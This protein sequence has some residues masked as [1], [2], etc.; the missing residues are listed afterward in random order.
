MNKLKNNVKNP[1]FLTAAG[2]LL[3]FAG[4]YLFSGSDVAGAASFADISLA[5]ALELPFAA[6]SVTGAVIHSMLSDSVGKCIVK[7]AA[8]SFIV[9]AKLFSGT[10]GTALSNAIITGISVMLSGTAIS[11]LIGEMPEKLLFYAL[12]ALLSGLAAG[13]GSYLLLSAEKDSVPKFN[14]SSGSCYAV[15]YIL[16]IASFYSIKV[17]AVNIGFIIGAALTL[18]GA[19]FYGSTGG[20]VCGALTA[21]GAFLTSPELGFSS[22]VLIAAGLF[23]GFVKKGGIVL[24]SMI[25]A[26]SCWGLTVLTGSAKY[27]A[28]VTLSILCGVSIFIVTAPYF[29][30]KWKVSEYNSSEIAGHRKARI[31]FLS[32]VIDAVRADAGRI[33]SALRSAEKSNGIPERKTVCEKCARNKVCERFNCEISTGLVPELPEKC[34]KKRELAAEYEQMLRERTVSNL[35]KLRF[36]HERSQLN[37]QLKLTGDILRNIPVSREARYSSAVSS[38]IMSVLVSHGIKPL[39]TDA[40]YT[41]S[42]R[43]AA[44]IYFDISQIPPAG[45][46]IRDLVSDEL[47]LHLIEGTAVASSREI[48]LSLYQKPEYTFKVCS[49]LVCAEGEDVSGDSNAA[50]TDSTGVC[51]IV[52]S[53]GMGTGKSAAV[54]SHMV[55]GLFK[56]LVCGGMDCVS[57]VKMANSVMLNK[58]QDESF[59]TLDALCLDPDRCS[60]TSVKSGAA[61]TLIRHGDSVMKISSANFPIG[62]SETAEISVAE[63]RLEAGDMLIM[64]SDGISENEYM[65][66][67]ELLLSDNDINDIVSET[68]LKASSFVQTTHNDDVTVIGVKIMN[69]Q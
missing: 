51:Y 43:L 3:S 32:D 68:A 37:E 7:L 42:N 59:A 1:A 22:A 15:I 26:A 27:G 49:A 52:L 60:V 53:D 19:F 58:S 40:F 61:A 34:V 33:S 67:K 30:D 66:I 24:R 28:D 36:A 45:S 21:F 2:I 48:R 8:M 47:R 11:V 39:R 46:R 20:L 65:F 23:T 50:F 38:K 14:G 16:Y 35:M 6:V 62:I 18:F 56:R 64:F 5:G 69:Y 29:P 17:P 13:C 9:I 10:K 25:F 4:G 44:E 63:H 57:A 54:D 12:Y 31:D 55:I 41:A